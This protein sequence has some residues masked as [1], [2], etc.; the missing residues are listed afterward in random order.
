M[1][2]GLYTAA[3]RLAF[4]CMVAAAIAQDAMQRDML[5]AHNAV[6]SKVGVP[7]LAWSDELARAAQQW[8]DR[9]I[10]EKRFDHRP[11]SKFG[12]N[13][14]EMRGAQATAAKVAERWAAEA[15]NFDL[16]SNKCKGVC[17]HY[18]Q[19]VWRDTKEVG[20]AVS[21]AAAARCGSASTRRP[22][23]TSDGGRTNFLFLTV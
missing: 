2:C 7:P 23:T 3:M 9:L 22:G 18:T 10:A 20:C 13:M 11:K 19:M 4:L 8:A 6:R 16:K 21:R 12:E 14:F 15:S 1:K 17:G 5:A